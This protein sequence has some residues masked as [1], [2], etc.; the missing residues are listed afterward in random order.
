MVRG[1][2]A[3]RGERFCGPGERSRCSDSLQDGWSGDRMPVGARDFVGRESVVGVATHYRMDD[4]E[5]ECRWGRDFPQPSRPAV[6]PT[7]PPV[8][9]VPGLFFRG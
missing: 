7:Q 1:S 5:I 2:D 9:W 6:E 8:Q 3:G 4:P